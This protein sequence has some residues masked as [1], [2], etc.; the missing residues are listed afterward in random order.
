MSHWARGDQ[1]AGPRGCVQQAEL[2]ADGVGDFAHDAAE[3]VNLA[4]EV[5]FGDASDG[6]VAG[7][8]RDEVDVEGVE[9]GLEAHAS[10]GDGGFAASVSGA[11]DGLRRNVR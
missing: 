2:D 11:D 7:H 9:G 10:A 4:D 8:L 6:G 5:A 3:R 1:T